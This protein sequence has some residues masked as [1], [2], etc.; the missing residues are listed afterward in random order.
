MNLL[1]E[2]FC[3][4][5][6]AEIFRVLFGLHSSELH[7]REIQR[8]TGFSLGAI[9]QDVGKLEK[10]GLLVRRRDGNR[11]YY[12]AN[13]KHP[14]H[15]EIRNIVLKTVG[16]ADI[17]SESLKSEDIQIAFIFGSIA[18]Q[19][20]S[21]ESDIDLMIIGKTSFRKV[22]QLLA[23]KGQLLG[24]EINSHVLSPDEFRKRLQKKE[25]LVTSILESKK[26]FVH[27]SEH[28]LEAMVR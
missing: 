2:L 22:S 11:V 25:H 10:L 21:A 28:D 15:P 26:I 19:N 14:I 4:K 8:R 20:F 12:S 6:R 18:T 13:V 27:G 9:Q 24:R 3:S 16:L 5:T 1:M 17:L 23:E 7:L